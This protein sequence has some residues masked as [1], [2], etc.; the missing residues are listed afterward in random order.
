MSVI[1]DKLLSYDVVSG[2][3]LITFI[4]IDT[5]PVYYI[6]SDIMKRMQKKVSTFYYCMYVVLY[7]IKADITSM[8]EDLSA[9]PSYIKLLL[10]INFFLNL[11]CHFISFLTK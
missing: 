1:I 6:F 5:T 11:N 4:K 7:T 8:N 9:Y 2:S 3:D 10:H